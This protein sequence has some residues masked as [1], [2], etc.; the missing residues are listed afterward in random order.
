MRFHRT[1]SRE[2]REIARLVGSVVCLIEE[3]HSPQGEE[4]EQ[5]CVR[6]CQPRQYI[7]GENWQLQNLGDVRR[8]TIRDTAYLKKRLTRRFMFNA[9][10]HQT[11][12]EIAERPEGTGTNQG[13]E[14]L[15]TLHA[16]MPGEQPPGGWAQIGGRFPVR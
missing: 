8:K 4:S 7:G 11:K 14:T 9:G 10:K 13:Q 3:S 2:L 5:N 6:R 12:S 16:V 1:R 15:V